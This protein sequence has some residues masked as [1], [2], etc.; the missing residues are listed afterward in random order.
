MTCA[1]GFPHAHSQY[2]AFSGG[3]EIIRMTA[4]YSPARIAGSAAALGILFCDVLLTD[5]LPF[6]GGS[7]RLGEHPRLLD[8]FAA[9]ASGKRSWSKRAPGPD[10]E[11]PGREPVGDV[12]DRDAARWYETCVGERPEQRFQI[13]GAARGARKELD[14]GSPE[15]SGEHDLRGGQHAGQHQNPGLEHRGQEFGVATRANEK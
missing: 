10:R 15:S 12:V 8:N 13:G 3:L 5:A 7:H 6:S 1:E 9:R 14:R 2:Q 11:G 4:S